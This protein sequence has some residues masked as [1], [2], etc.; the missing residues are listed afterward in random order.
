[1]RDTLAGRTQPHRVT[2]LIWGTAPLIAAFAAFAN[3]VRWAALPVLMTGLCPALIFLASFHN[4][5]AYW[6]TKPSDYVCGASSILALVLWRVTHEP[7]IAIL[8]A[9]AS[10]TLAAVPT[11]R[12]AWTNPESET[13]SAYVF[14]W[15]SLS[16]SL[17]AAPAIT[18]SACAF[19]IALM[20]SNM[21]ILY[22]LKREKISSCLRSLR[23]GGRAN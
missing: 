12:K 22:A 17:L 8:F 2:F 16:T 19:P 14:S 10:D 23:S 4:K 5:N 13:I 9:I 7:N 11:M 3:G 6:K 20:L 18:F 21:I 15:L 1:M